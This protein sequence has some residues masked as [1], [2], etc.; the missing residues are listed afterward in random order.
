MTLSFFFFEDLTPLF[1]FQLCGP[2]PANARSWA[3][4]TVAGAPRQL[5]PPRPPPLPRRSPPSAAGPRRPRSPGTPTAGTT[6]TRHR[7]PKRWGCRACTRRCCTGSTTTWWWPRRG[8]PGCRRSAT[9]PSRCTPPARHTGP[10]LTPRETSGTDPTQL[11]LK[12]LSR[13]LYR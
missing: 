5:G 8:P 11:N 13:V 1:F 2:A 12:E 4:R 7:S 9:S 6:T 3:T 10:P